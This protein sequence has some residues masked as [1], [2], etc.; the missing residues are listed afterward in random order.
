[1]AKMC[2]TPSLPWHV[3]QV[4][5]HGHDRVVQAPFFF[6]EWKILAKK[7]LKH[8]DNV[9]IGPGETFSFPAMDGPGCI[10]NMWF[11]FTPF[12]ITRMLK[13]RKSWNARK[14]LRIQI[15]FDDNQIP[16]VDAPIGDFFGVGFGEYKEYQSKYLEEC[17]GGYVCRFPM[18]FKENARV[19]IANTDEKQ[20]VMAFYGAI[21]YKRFDMPLENDPFYFH[22]IY[23]E[24][25]PTRKQIPYKI[26]DVHGDGFYAGVVL[27]IANTRRGHSFTF[28]EGNTKIFVDGSTVPSLEYTGTED[29]FQGAW[30]YMS[31]EYSASYSGLTVRSHARENFLSATINGIFTKNKTSQYRFHEHDAVPFKKSLLVFIHHGEFDEVPTRESS[32][33]YF[34]ARKPVEVN[35]SPLQAGEF[36]DEYYG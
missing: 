17:S 22:A 36:T 20:A 5:T 10:V 9:R 15:Y 11:T 35:M 29:L 32:V 16:S 30:Y 23:R 1:M 7:G 27:N 8:R 21:T 25:N 18:P 33:T 3:F 4:S 2:M 24:E 12:H 28:L 26:I 14:K 13:Y 19:A 31:G 6:P 34:Y